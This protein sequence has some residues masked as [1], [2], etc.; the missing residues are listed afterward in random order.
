MEIKTTDEQVAAIEPEL[1][2]LIIKE[3]RLYR[4]HTLLTYGSKFIYRDTMMA[5]PRLSQVAIDSLVLNKAISLVAPPPLASLP[6]WS[7]RANR[8]IDLGISNVAQLLGTNNE[9]LAAH[10][11]VKAETIGKWKSEAR[12]W[13]TATPHTSG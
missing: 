9:A 12:K 2:E 8:L 1:L 11:K 7:R 4:V 3:K 6:G 10:L 13:L 5:F